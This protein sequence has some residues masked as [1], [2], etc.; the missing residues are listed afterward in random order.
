MSAPSAMP[1]LSSSGSQTLPTPPSVGVDLVRIG[2]KRAVVISVLDTVAVHVAVA[3]VARTVAIE[4]RLVRIRCQ[5]AVVAPL[6]TPSP[7][8]SSSQTSPSPSPSMSAWPS[9]R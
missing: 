9:S 3:R 7:S 1:S 4:V 5:R 2:L 6:S 8:T